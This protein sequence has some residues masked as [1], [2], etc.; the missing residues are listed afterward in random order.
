MNGAAFNS[1]TSVRTTCI[2][3]DSVIVHWCEYF[4]SCK[5]TQT[6]LLL[7]IN[8]CS[9]ILFLNCRRCRRFC[10]Q[11]MN[12]L[13]VHTVYALGDSSPSVSPAISTYKTRIRTTMEL[14]RAADI[15]TDDA[16]CVL[17]TTSNYSTQLSGRLNVKRDK[18]QQQQQQQNPRRRKQYSKIVLT[19]N[20]SEEE[21]T[22]TASYSFVEAIWDGLS[23]TKNARTLHWKQWV[24]RRQTPAKQCTRRKKAKTTIHKRQKQSKENE[25]YENRKSEKKNERKKN[26]EINKWK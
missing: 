5:R 24:M 8:L 20:K 12:I 16:V 9:G 15:H 7:L 18:K 21:E 26:E 10:I 6:I 19:T 14:A 13:F 4:Y 11:V 23:Y 22:W 2:V 3:R 1:C 17:E 25:K